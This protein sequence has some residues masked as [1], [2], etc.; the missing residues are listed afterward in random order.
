MQIG[1]AGPTTAHQLGSPGW[2]F[3]NDRHTDD[4]ALVRHRTDLMHFHQ[5]PEG[6]ADR[7]C[8]ADGL[9]GARATVRGRPG[10]SGPVGI[11]RVPLA[12]V[13]TSGG[14]AGRK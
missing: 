10:S 12:L 11:S 4:P 2:T 8:G 13:S 9:P 7:P 14:G 6:G 3:E 1:D 5:L